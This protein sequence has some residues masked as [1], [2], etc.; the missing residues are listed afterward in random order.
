MS[1]AERLEV[2]ERPLLIGAGT[3]AAYRIHSYY[4]SCKYPPLRRAENLPFPP[5]IALPL[6]RF[7]FRRISL[8]QRFLYAVRQADEQ[9]SAGSFGKAQR[10]E[11]R[12]FTG[13]G[14]PLDPGLTRHPVWV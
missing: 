14:K 6:F 1:F 5:R 8:P 11:A 3:G 13:A 10:A 4:D 2:S 9:N 12:T 7:L